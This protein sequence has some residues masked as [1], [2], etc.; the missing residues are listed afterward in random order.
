MNILVSLDSNYV[1]PICVMFRSLVKSTPNERFDIYVAYS[2]LTEEDFALMEKALAG[3]DFKLHRIKV[4]DEIF[5]DAP[6]LSRL[7]KETYYR[8]LIGD[9]LPED[10]HKIL[11]IDPDTAINRNLAEFYNT[12]VSDYVLAAAPHLKG[13]IEKGNLLRLGMKKTSR[14][15]NAGVLLINLD[16]WR[17]TVTL[18]QILG[19]ISENIKKLLL[20]DQ[21]VVNVLFENNTLYV[22][23]RLYNLDEK[24]YKRYSAKSAGKKQINIDWVR[25]NTVIVH[26][27]GKHKPWREKNYAGKL[28]EFFEKNKDF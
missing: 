7:S 3:S 1:Y 19:F 6:V 13:I 14:Y 24:V 25:K 16:K 21:D 9:I 18:K 23:E 15:I 11:Y 20:A 5:A 8:L 4:G 10:V 12:D 17:E 22:D 28:G 26:F 27:N 2:S